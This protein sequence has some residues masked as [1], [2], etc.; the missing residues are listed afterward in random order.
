[1]KQPRPISLV[2]FRVVYWAIA[3]LAPLVVVLSMQKYREVALNQM[4]VMLY[5]IGA[6]GLYRLLL[7]FA[8]FFTNDPAVEDEIEDSEG[9]VTLHLTDR[10]E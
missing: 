4:T 9:R 5:G 7:L 3:I 6:A 10:D 8:R 1:M 2:V